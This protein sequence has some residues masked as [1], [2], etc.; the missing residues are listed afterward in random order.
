[1]NA[2]RLGQFSENTVR[3]VFDLKN[4]IN[5]QVFQDNNVFSVIFSEGHTVEDIQVTREG[6]MALV[7][8][9]AD[10]EIGYEL[11]ADKNKKQ[12]KIVMPGVAIGK[13]LLNQDVI[14]ITDDIIEYI[15]LV[16]VKDAKNYNFEI[17]ISLNSFA[18]YEMLSS[19][20]SSLI[21]LGIH[22]S[23]LKNKPIVIDPGHGGIEPGA[24]VGNVKEKI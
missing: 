14:K 23:P 3:V 1:M 12:L 17:I 11:K 7:E 8:I 15:E 13:N 20:P 16:K 18:S 2:V 4:D 19:P 5:Y 6:D 24:V 22:K 9:A 21:R 10:G